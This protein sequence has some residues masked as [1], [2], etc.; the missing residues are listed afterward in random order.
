MHSR[1]AFIK[2]LSINDYIYIVTE[3]GIPDTQNAVFKANNDFSH[4]EIPLD[5]LV[6]SGQLPGWA[7]ALIVIGSLIVGG[8]GGFIA[9]K[10]FAAKKPKSEIKKSLL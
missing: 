3:E 6:N 5:I 7:I 2:E 9:W 1:Q 8:L 4:F 10:K